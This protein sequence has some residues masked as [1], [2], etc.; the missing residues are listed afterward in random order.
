M[1]ST[2]PDQLFH[3]D[4]WLTYVKG[5]S[6][7][8]KEVR[9]P[10]CSGRY[11]LFSQ[12][13]SPLSALPESFQLYVK[14]DL[15]HGGPLPWGSHPLSLP[16]CPHTASATSLLQSVFNWHA[17]MQ[18]DLSSGSSLLPPRSWTPPLPSVSYTHTLSFLF[19]LFRQHFGCNSCF[20]E[21][22]HTVHDLIWHE[23]WRL[24]IIALY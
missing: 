20:S 6:S 24:A 23:G 17:F 12:S 2:K 5:D 8:V 18:H 11:R 14:H 3:T 4:V 15:S 21:S 19:S 13:L 16:I 22:G 9:H 1:G 10:F 7:S